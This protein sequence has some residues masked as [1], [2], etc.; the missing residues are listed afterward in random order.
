MQSTNWKYSLGVTKWIATLRRVNSTSFAKQD[1]FPKESPWDR[2]VS[3][4]QF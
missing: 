2:A 4:A 1:A 3:P